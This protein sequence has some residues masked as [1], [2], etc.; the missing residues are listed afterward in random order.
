MYDVYFGLTNPPQKIISN[1]T[2]SYYQA[3]LLDCNMTYYWKIVSWDKKGGSGSSVVWSF[4]TIQL[5]QFIHSF[6]IGRIANTNEHDDVVTF[7]AVKTL[8]ITFSP[9]QFTIC[10]QN[11]RVVIDNDYIGLLGSRY[12]LA[13]CKIPPS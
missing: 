9:F 10:S 5:Q 1:Q 8:K 3:D 13:F 7:D 12:I 11:D 6:I 4:Y 2:D